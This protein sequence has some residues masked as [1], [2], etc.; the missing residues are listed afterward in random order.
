[1]ELI[2]TQQ[3]PQPAGHYSQA[4]VHGNLVY[5]SGQL[6]VVPETGERNA[7]DIEAQVVRTLKNAEAILRAAR[8]HLSHVLKVTVYITDISLWSRVNRVY[9]EFFGAHRPARSVVPVKELHYGC[10]VEIDMIAAVA[11][12]LS[13]F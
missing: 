9:G 11:E 4:V 2:S 1:M 10:Q 13:Q 12:P 6:P 8:S 3:A 5:V 7:G